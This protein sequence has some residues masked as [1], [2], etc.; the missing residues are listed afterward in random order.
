MKLHVGEQARPSD[1]EDSYIIV[2]PQG[3]LQQMNF[4][5]LFH[6][7]KWDYLHSVS[8]DHVFVKKELRKIYM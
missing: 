7:F 8:D 2:D 3:L 5:K 6:E 4:F 1:T